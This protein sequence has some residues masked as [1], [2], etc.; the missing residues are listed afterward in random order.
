MARGIRD[1]DNADGFVVSNEACVVGS[2]DAAL[3]VNVGR[4]EV[5]GLEWDS[6]IWI[7]KSGIHA[8]SEVFDPKQKGRSQLIVTVWL[9]Q[10]RGWLEGEDGV[11]AAPKTK[12]KGFFGVPL[13]PVPP[14]V[15]R[16]K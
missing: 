3:K 13:P 8:K 4:P 9:A 11:T 2:S 15:P 1:D 12:A 16:K 6:E 10:Q 5:E 7:P 14:T